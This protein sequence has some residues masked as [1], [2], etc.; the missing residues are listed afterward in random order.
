LV[1]VDGT[2]VLVGDEVGVGVKVCVAG[3]VGLGGIW[4][5]A[6]VPVTVGVGVAVPVLVLVGVYVGVSVLAK[7]VGCKFGVPV[8]AMVGLGVQVKVTGG[9]RVGT[10][11]GPGANCTAIIPAQ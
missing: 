3:R 4:V 1:A 5:G 6:D 9:V 2:G 11:V 8:A 7:L 10:G